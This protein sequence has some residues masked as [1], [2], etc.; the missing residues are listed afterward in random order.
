MQTVPL[1][2]A[3]S[4]VLAVTSKIIIVKPISD[5]SALL[6]AVRVVGWPTASVFLLAVIRAAPPCHVTL[7]VS[8]ATVGFGSVFLVKG[9]APIYA[10][11]VCEIGVSSTGMCSES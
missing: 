1:V 5:T 9:Y 2:H 3:A 8:N 6:V 4:L 11:Y 7:R 10:V